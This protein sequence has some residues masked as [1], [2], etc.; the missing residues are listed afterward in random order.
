MYTNF[1][2][3]YSLLA[4]MFC[5]CRHAA[6][7]VSLSVVCCREP[8]EGSDVVCWPIAIVAV[9]IIGSLRSCHPSPI[10]VVAV[11]IALVVAA[12]QCGRRHHQ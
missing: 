12:Q 11:L 9:R 2:L 8:L 5:V 10:F 3:G 6:V 7:R 4:L 1:Q